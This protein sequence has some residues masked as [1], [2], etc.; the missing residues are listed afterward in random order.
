MKKRK[1]YTTPLVSVMNVA[2]GN[3]LAASGI[4]GK[5][6]D[7]EWEIQSDNA[8]DEHAALRPYF[9][10]DTDNGDVSLIR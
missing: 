3:I 4:T 10:E 6:D 9:S 7:F 8:N 1:D 5:G 2:T